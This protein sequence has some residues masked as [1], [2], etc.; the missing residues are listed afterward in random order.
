MVHTS[1]GYTP[2]FTKFGREATLPVHCVYPVSKADREME[3]SAWTETMQERFQTAYAG[4][5][6]K[7]QESVRRNAQYYKITG[8]I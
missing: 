6:E 5:K 1:K 7:Q 8:R 4:M 2:F 3:L